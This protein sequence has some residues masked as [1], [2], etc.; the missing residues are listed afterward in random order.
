MS[1]ENIA[2]VP[3]PEKTA[4][5]KYLDSLLDKSSTVPPPSVVM[6]F[7]EPD[8]TQS[9]YR[10]VMTLGNLSVIQ[11]KSK[12]G[13]TFL[14][15]LML[16]ALIERRLHLDKFVGNNEVLQ[17]KQGIIFADTEQGEYD[18]YQ[19]MISICNKC[20]H[21][22]NFGY[23]MTRKHTPAERIDIIQAA[24]DMG[25]GQY[26]VIFIDGIADLT[27]AYNDE[28][29]AS[30]LVQQL[31]TWTE[32]YNC[33]ICNVVHEN[34]AKENT[35]AT[36]WLGKILYQKA[37]TV[38]SVESTNEINVKKV[39]SKLQRGTRQ[40]EPFYFS[41]NDGDAFIYEKGQ[42]GKLENIY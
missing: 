1:T 11:G 2:V 40:F 19:T 35:D 21:S 38:I 9:A 36:G 20:T 14:L 13:K 8:G 6:Q 26:G 28:E 3:L 37:E 18:A 31:M 27:T 4:E 32:V 5:Q 15:R 34:K 33:H 22:Q 39:S 7:K 29:K 12:A 42:Y 10:R 24:L 17:H 23:S 25:A 41:I 16:P 30:K